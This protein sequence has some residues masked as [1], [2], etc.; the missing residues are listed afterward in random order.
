MEPELTAMRSER[1]RRMVIHKV[2][3]EDEYNKKPPI[4]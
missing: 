3:D 2:A 4:Q 1:R